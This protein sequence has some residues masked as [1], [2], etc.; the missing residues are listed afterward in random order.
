M[1]QVLSAVGVRSDIDRPTFIACAREVD[2]WAPDLA[3]KPVPGRAARRLAAMLLM[4][5]LN[6]NLA[7]QSSEVFGAIRDLR[8]VPA[9]QASSTL[10]SPQR[11]VFPT[12]SVV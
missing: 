5:E 6:A 8:C 9:T 4:Q 12:P 3:S 10:L 1:L 2:G 11:L 7:L